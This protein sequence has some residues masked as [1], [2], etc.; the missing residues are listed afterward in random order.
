MSCLLSLRR[1][2]M[3]SRK[4]SLFFSRIPL[5][6]YKTFPNKQVLCQ[7][8]IRCDTTHT[9]GAILLSFSPP[10]HNVWFQ[11][12]GQRVWVWHNRDLS[13]EDGKIC[14]KGHLRCHFLAS[15]AFFISEIWRCDC[16]TECLLCSFSSRVKSVPLGN[17]L[18]SFTSANKPS[19]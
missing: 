11:I 16:L 6:S 4:V 8:S 18:S 13:A 10:Q 3:S 14:K 7:K 9:N 17:R 5:T 12:D 19:F 1:F 2:R 15:T